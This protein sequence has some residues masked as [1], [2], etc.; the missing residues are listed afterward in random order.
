MRKP[1]IDP[2]PAAELCAW[3]ERHGWTSV[4]A[5]AMLNTPFDTYRGWE[6]PDARAPGVTKL[7]MQQLDAQFPLS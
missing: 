6:K 1:K 2:V 3:R 5:A 7:A 4:V